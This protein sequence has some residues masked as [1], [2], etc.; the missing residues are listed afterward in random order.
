MASTCIALWF[1]LKQW[2]F[3]YS[4]SFTWVADAA[5]RSSLLFRT[6]ANVAFHLLSK[7]YF[8]FSTVQCFVERQTDTHM[9]IFTMKLHTLACSFLP[10]IPKRIEIESLLL[11]FLWRSIALSWISVCLLSCARLEV[12]EELFKIG[13][14]LFLSC[15]LLPKQPLLAA[16][17][18]SFDPLLL[19]LILSFMHP[20][21]GVLVTSVHVI[22]ILGSALSVGK[23]SV[24]H[25]DIIKVD[26]G[27][28]VF[29]IVRMEEFRQFVICLVNFIH[30]C[31]L[32]HSEHLYYST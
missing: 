15:L 12:G 5:F 11:L 1:S 30:S 29:I 14:L 9:H 4:F 31:S 6:L 24:S 20:C 21:S 3:L 27:V 17:L 8:L 32:R 18:Y 10:T 2:V 28:R 26:F 7:C 25:G 13:L 23:G 22:V 16:L 19:H